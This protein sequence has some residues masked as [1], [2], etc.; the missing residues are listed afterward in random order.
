MTGLMTIENK[1]ARHLPVNIERRD[2]KGSN[3]FSQIQIAPKKQSG[4]TFNI[5]YHDRF[6][7]RRR[8]SRILDDVG[9]IILG[10]PCRRDD[11]PAD[12]CGYISPYRVGIR[13]DNLPGKIER[14]LKNCLPVQRA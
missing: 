2:E 3:A 4:I 6:F 14:G 13:S 12:S 1:R 11:A 10:K 7:K 9:L 8:R 5:F